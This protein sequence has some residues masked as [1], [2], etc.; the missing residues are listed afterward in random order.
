MRNFIKHLVLISF[1]VFI[2]SVKLFAQGPESAVKSALNNLFS[3]SKSKAYDKAAL[4]IA[5]DGEDK[6]RSQKESYNPANK[7]ELNQAKRKCKEIAALIELSNKYEVGKFSTSTLDGKEVYSI[8]V[9]FI[10]GEQKLLKTY[11][12]IKAVNGYLLIKVS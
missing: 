8:D 1:I 6:N 9:N 7:D 11:T 12:F 10:S 2:S 3:Y 5:Y 4:L